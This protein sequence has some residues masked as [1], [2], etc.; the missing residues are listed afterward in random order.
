MINTPKEVAT[1]DSAVLGLKAMA[2]FWEGQNNG[3]IA[4]QTR[5]LAE[6]VKALADKRR[7]SSPRSAGTATVR[8]LK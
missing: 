3:V 6:K 7:L 8:V 4:L 1:L 5:D 2:D